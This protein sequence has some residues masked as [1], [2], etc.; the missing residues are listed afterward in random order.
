MEDPYRSIHLGSLQSLTFLL[1][2]TL[3]GPRLKKKRTEQGR[4]QY[5][6]WRP[7]S[8]LVTDFHNHK[9]TQFWSNKWLMDKSEVHC[10]LN[11][12]THIWEVSL[13]GFQVKD[14]LSQMLLNVQL[15]QVGFDLS[16][17]TASPTNASAAIKMTFDHSRQISKLIHHICSIWPQYKQVWQNLT[18]KEVTNEPSDF[19]S[20]T[21][22]LFHLQKLT[23][24]FG[25]DLHRTIITKTYIKWAAIKYKYVFCYYHILSYSLGFIF[26]FLFN[27]V[28]Y[29]FLL[30]GLRILIVLLP[31]LRF[32]RAFSSVVRQI[33]G[34]NS[35][36]R[37]TARTLPKFLCC[38]QNFCVVLCIVCFVSFCV[39]FVFK[40]VLY[41]CHRV[42]TQLKLTNIS[43]SISNSP[44]D[45]GPPYDL[46]RLYKT[47]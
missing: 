29:V 23:T 41:N 47:I 9:H 14:G 32:F 16:I 12:H 35:P 45:K 11:S 37:G 40:C 8:C 7:R 3:T 10:R 27:T 24:C 19:Q 2:L 31:W 17:F 5:N 1:F 39:L 43:I 20:N 6:L 42:A 22:S 33:P 36:N 26:V 46:Q 34:Y 30:L 13:S 21:T 25:L 44:R 18:L 28:I 4:T 15:W 38:S